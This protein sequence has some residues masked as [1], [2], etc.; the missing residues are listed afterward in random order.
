MSINIYT[1][2]SDNKCRLFPFL[3]TVIDI[4]KIKITS[5]SKCFPPDSAIT[6]KVIFASH[7]AM[8]TTVDKS[9]EI[10]ERL[11]NKIKISYVNNFM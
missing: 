2:C 10:L 11:K 9:R 4:I 6:K 3:E 8:F 1:K 5:F 7:S